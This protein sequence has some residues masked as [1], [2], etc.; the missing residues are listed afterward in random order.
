[1]IRALVI[2][3]VL[4]PTV[5]HAQDAGS[6]AV[7]APAP[8]GSAPTSSADAHLA[9]ARDLHARGDFAHARDELQAAYALDP[10]PELLFA[11]GQVELNLG[12]YRAAIDY[13]DKFLATNP[14][15]DQ[16]ALAQQAI[17]AARLELDRPPPPPPPRAA[18]PPVYAHRWD[19][20]DSTLVAVGGVAA[21]VGGA[22]LY[23]AHALD[24]DHSGTLKTYDERFA[25]AQTR[26]LEGIIGISAGIAL[27]AAALVRWR[28]TEVEVHV[29]VRGDGGAVTWG[30]AW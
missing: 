23:D 10:R 21:L 26:R 12:H 14:A 15:E 30:R 6:G 5:A 8:A 25:R 1:M 24:D 19:G 20:I 13:Y 16:A 11:L 3:L 4:A 27:A 28:V 7:P 18:P 2:S 29:D 22:L 17:G 9:R